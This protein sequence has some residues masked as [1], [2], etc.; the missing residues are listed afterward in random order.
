MGL[1]HYN[2]C[3][4]GRHPALVAIGDNLAELF[5]RLVE[6]PTDGCPCCMAIR[7]LTFATLTFAA[8]IGVGL[9]V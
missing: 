9:L 3:K 8:G 7:I 5:Q 1:Y 4:I 6:D 2:P